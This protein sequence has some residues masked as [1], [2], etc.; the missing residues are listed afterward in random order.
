MPHD[1]RETPYLDA[2]LR[3]RADRLHAVPHARDTS[4]A[5]ARRP[6]CASSSATRV[7][8]PTSPWPAAW[9]T[10]AS[11]RA[12]SASRRTTP[13]RRGAADRAWFLVNGSTSGVH[14]LLLTLCGPGDTVIVPRNAHKSMLAGLIFTG[15]M[16]LYMEPAIDPVWGIPLQVRPADALAAL[17]EAPDARALFVTSPTYNGL[18]ADLP[19]IG[20]AG[21]RRRHPVRHRPGVGPAPALLRRTAGR[22]HDRRRGRSRGQHAQAHQRPDPVVGA[23]GARRAR[24]P[25]APRRHGPHDPEHQPAGAHV[26]QHRRR[27]AADGGARRRAVARRRRARD[28]GARAHH[29]SCP[30]CAVWAPRCSGATAS[31]SSTPHGSPSRP[32]TSA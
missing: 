16:P 17:S 2:A 5:R 23:P 22:R 7:S 10:R 21:A 1:Q 11:P 20:D 29:A 28:L 24:Q 13:P 15:A 3:Y 32:A 25:R 14:A 18:G 30:V 8:R 9:R 31:P 27:P 6:A 12:S 26:R 4:W 19:G